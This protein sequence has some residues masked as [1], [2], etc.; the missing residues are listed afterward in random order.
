[1]ATGASLVLLDGALASLSGSGFECQSG[2]DVSTIMMAVFFSLMSVVVILS[3]G[4]RAV[5]V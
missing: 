4:G 1:M 5:R 2:S 3:K